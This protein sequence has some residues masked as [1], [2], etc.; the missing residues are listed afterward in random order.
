MTK[1]IFNLDNILSALLSMYLT[2]II[3]FSFRINSYVYYLCPLLFLF[4]LFS[5][6]KMFSF[7]EKKSLR[8]QTKENQNISLKELILYALLIFSTISLAIIFYFP[9]NTSPDIVF[10]FNQAITNKYSDWHPV[11]HTLIFYKIPTLFYKGYISCTIFQG[12]FVGLILLYFAKFC[13]K[14]F[15]TCKQTIF[16]LLLFLANPSFFSMVTT[17]WKDIPFSYCVMLGTMFLIEIFITKGKWLDSTKNK[18][19]FILMSFG[20]V[21][22]RHNGIV[23]FLLMIILLTIFYKNKRKFLIIFTII[24][25]IARSI[26]TG[27]IYNHFKVAPNGG[28]GEMLGVPLNQISY[29][30][31]T[32]GKVNK[33]ELKVIKR[34]APLE[35]FKKYFLKSN[36]NAIKWSGNYN[37]KYVSKHYKDVLKAWYSMA[38]KNPI[39]A[40]ESYIYVTN[41][42]WKIDGNINFIYSYGKNRTTSILINYNSIVCNSFL[43]IFVVDVG[44]GLLFILISLM[45]MIKKFK[46]NYKAYIPYVLAISNVL[47]IMLLI[48]GGEV[49]FVYSSILASYPLVIYSLKKYPKERVKKVS[50]ENVVYQFLKYSIVGFIAAVVNISMLYVFTDM[51]KINYIISNVIA[52]ILGLI[53]NYILSKKMVFKNEEIKN[54]KLEF[55]IYAIIGVIGLILDTLILFLLVSKFK[56]YY[57]LGKIISTFIVFIWNFGARKIFYKLFGGKL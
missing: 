47:V 39:K 36:F 54:G 37:D 30:Y 4:F 31:N 43:K 44:N 2:F 15:L 33:K 6:K 20:V 19:L 51:C 24:F 5:S 42:I 38:I 9:S 55:L 34:I 56:M 35:D 26:I 8:T 52:F 11:F 13:R 12:L 46:T 1:K 21:F 17:P 29:I 48:T 7:L 16:V 10:Q 14:Y 49:R 27:P 32:G 28:Y 45:L 22:F 3:V 23:S 18:I 41:P 53:T 57:M 40:V 50:K 25:L